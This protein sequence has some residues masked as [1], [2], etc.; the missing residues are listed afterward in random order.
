ME[1]FVFVSA[2]VWGLLLAL[3]LQFTT[4]GRWLAIHRTWVTVV[5]GVGIDLLIA[6]AILP[7]G[8][9]GK[10]VLIFALSS[11]AIIARSLV[12]E[13]AETEELINGNG[14]GEE[15]PSG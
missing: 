14:N 7:L 5:I 4:I 6:L 2:L 9:W 15:G 3:F 8:L 11:V 1:L 12:N 13:L 10:V